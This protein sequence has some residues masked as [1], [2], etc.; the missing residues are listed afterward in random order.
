[1]MAT[2]LPKQVKISDLV[3]PGL[4]DKPHLTIFFSTLRHSFS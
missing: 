3:L 2:S 4:G 1:M